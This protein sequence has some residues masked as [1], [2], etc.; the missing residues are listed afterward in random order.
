MVI[1]ASYNNLTKVFRYVNADGAEI[2]F[3][4]DHG[5]LIN[6]PNGIDTVSVTVNESYGINQVGTSVNS[7]H[8]ESRPITFSGKV[9]GD[10]QDAKKKRLLDVV[11]PGGAGKLYCDDY[12]INVRPTATPTVGPETR[13]ASFQFS[14]L[15][16][17]PYWCKD[18]TQ[19]ETIMGVEKRFKFPWNMSRQYRF[20]EPWRK[21][22]VNVY[23]SGQTEIPFRITL[24][25]L[26]AA[27]NPRIQNAVTG[28]FLLINKDMVPDER[29]VIDITHDRTSVYSSV[30]G[31]CRGALDITSNLFRL[32]IG[33]NV[34]KPTADSG[35]DDMQIEV[36][37]APEIVGMHV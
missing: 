37:F 18:D 32:N 12:Y 36:T 3:L 13:N 9:V 14:L 17:Y 33:D 29:L 8:V 31:D 16:P 27:K 15:A 5:Y 25:S 34:L 23:N 24:V 21:K 35:L 10:G 22:F 28:Q 2:T 26:A 19:T 11:R 6:K 20:G 4:F 30:D 7:E 1:T